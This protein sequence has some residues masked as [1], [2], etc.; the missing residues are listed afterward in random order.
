L[1]SLGSLRLSEWKWGRNGNRV[2][3]MYIGELRGVEEGAI[4]VKMYY[5][6]NSF[7]TF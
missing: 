7:S 6:R 4:L 5:M 2:E 3:E 1:I